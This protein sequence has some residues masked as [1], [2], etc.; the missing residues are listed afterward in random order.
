[1]EQPDA[2]RPEEGRRV[3]ESHVQTVECAQIQEIRDVAGRHPRQVKLQVQAQ[4]VEDLQR[5]GKRRVFFEKQGFQA[6]IK[7]A[8][9]V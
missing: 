3:P 4:V 5:E 2:R 6:T 9:K 1:M 7:G 8:D